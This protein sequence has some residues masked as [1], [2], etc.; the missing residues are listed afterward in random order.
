MIGSTVAMKHRLYQIALAACQLGIVICMM[1]LT[2][3]PS[4]LLAGILFAA[5]FTSSIVI[6][7]D[8][9]RGIIRWSVAVLYAT[10]FA[11]SFYLVWRAETVSPEV[12]A[13]AVIFGVEGCVLVAI[14]AVT[15]RW[16]AQILRKITCKN[17]WKNLWKYSKDGKVGHPKTSDRVT[18]LKWNEVKPASD[19]PREPIFGPGA[20]GALLHIIVR[21]LMAFLSG[22]SF[23][24]H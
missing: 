5:I 17:A 12:V 3:D 21:V 13:G 18:R 6:L 19:K 23:S 2:D 4:G 15:V 8:L 22:G 7:L 16:M 20:P 1:V 11:A 10:A 9:P 24:S 14:G